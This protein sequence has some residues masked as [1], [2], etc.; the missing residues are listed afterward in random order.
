MSEDASVRGSSQRVEK[1]EL[2][3]QRS[4]IYSRL[5]GEKLA[6]RRE[7]PEAKRVRKHGQP[8][9]VSG[10]T[11][12]PYQ[13]EGLVWL[14]SLFENG[15]NG[16]LADEMGL[17]K[18]L[19]TIAFLAHL[20]ENGVTGPFLVVAPLSTTHNWC[21]EFEKC[22]LANRFAPS[23]TVMLYHGTKD[24]RAALRKELSRK[25]GRSISVLVTSYDI[26]LQDRRFLGQT[27]WKYLVVDEAHRLKN[28]DCK[29]VAADRLLRELK[30]FSSA[31]R[32]IITGTPLHVRSR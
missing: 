30:A 17:G 18:T 13:Q 32:L 23:I 29:C 8:E 20:C 5:M 28:L 2:L 21:S 26:V 19:Q 10:A 31:N 22:A 16:I 9:S 11:L 7:Q 4:G 14:T 24:K 3:L 25:L 15:L 27:A 12:K 6:K 1:L